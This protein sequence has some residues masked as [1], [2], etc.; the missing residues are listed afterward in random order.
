MGHAYKLMDITPF[1]NIKHP[2]IY[3]WVPNQ[4]VQGGLYIWGGFIFEGL[5]IW[6]ACIAKTFAY[7]L[8]SAT[9]ENP[10]AIL[11]ARCR[12]KNL[13]RAVLQLRS[14]PRVPVAGGPLLECEGSR[15]RNSKKTPSEE[16]RDEGFESHNN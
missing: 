16:R 15:G 12:R 1:P 14:Q 2:R 5:H 7:A 11:C 6:G 13:Q 3:I 4:G 8:N 9:K 10:K